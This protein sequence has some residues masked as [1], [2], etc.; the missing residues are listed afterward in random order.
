MVN[1]IDLFGPP[2][3]VDLNDFGRGEEYPN[4]VDTSVSVD[5]ATAMALGNLSAD[6]FNIVGGV[7]RE[8]LVDGDL[9]FN[10]TSVFESFVSYLYQPEVQPYMMDLTGM[11]PSMANSTQSSHDWTR[12]LSPL[13]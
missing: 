6:A 4:N 5:V 9:F 8:T 12:P 7:P 13:S 2:Q 1:G 3:I 11:S 10:E